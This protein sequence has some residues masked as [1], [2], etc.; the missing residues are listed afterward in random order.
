MGVMMWY[1]ELFSSFRRIL[2]LLGKKHKII[3]MFFFLELNIKVLQH[4]QPLMMVYD[5]LPVEISDVP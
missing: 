4:F 2:E 5:D 1:D 3:I